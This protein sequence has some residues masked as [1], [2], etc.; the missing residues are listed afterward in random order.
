[1]QSIKQVISSLWDAS[2]WCSKVSGLFK[3][4]L[5]VDKT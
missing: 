2:W 3:R 1:M 4:L 5:V